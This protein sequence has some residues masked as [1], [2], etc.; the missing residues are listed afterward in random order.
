MSQPE[1]RPC[2]FCKIVAA[3][4][5]AKIVFRDERVTAF[6]DLE[7]I[8]EHH[9][10]IVPNRHIASLNDLGPE[11]E[12]L[13]GYMVGVARQIAAG[14]GFADKGY[15]LIVNTGAGGGQTVFHLH[16]HLIAGKRSRFRI[17]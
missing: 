9:I 10:L 15:R 3:E 11:D 16:L 2:I 8:A 5:P 7:P 13:I 17:G 6:H 12:P 4:A 1:N 14:Q